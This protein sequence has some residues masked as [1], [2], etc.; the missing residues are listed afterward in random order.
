M[1][2]QS[3]YDHPMQV[4]LD[5]ELD[6]ELQQ[7]AEELGVRK[8]TLALCGCKSGCKSANGEP[9]K[10]GADAIRSRLLLSQK[11]GFHTYP[12]HEPLPA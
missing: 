12:G 2:I 9:H 3:V 8:S 1:R 6:S 10:C 4:R 7:L 11:R 5:A